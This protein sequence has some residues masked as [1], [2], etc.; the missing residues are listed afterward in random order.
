[1]KK[2]KTAKLNLSDLEYRIGSG[3]DIILTDSDLQDKYK[4]LPVKEVQH[5]DWP[6]F[7]L[8]ARAQR[9]VY[10]DRDLKAIIFKDRFDDLLKIQREQAELAK[11]R[12][13]YICNIQLEATESV[14]CN[15]CYE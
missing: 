9:V 15:G 10:I 7:T 4:N 8:I 11:K 3:Y 12:H 13:C 14:C 5:F 6:T 1:M 2:L